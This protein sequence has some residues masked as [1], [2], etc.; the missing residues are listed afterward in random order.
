MDDDSTQAP[1]RQPDRGKP[2]Q[3]PEPRTKQPP[4]PPEREHTD[5]DVDEAGRESFPASDPPSFTPEG[6]GARGA[7]PPHGARRRCSAPFR[8]GRESL[9]V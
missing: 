5:E 9:T 7:P 6:A 3:E 1:S 2:K 4:A 8:G